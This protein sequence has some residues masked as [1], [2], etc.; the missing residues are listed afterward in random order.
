VDWERVRGL[1]SRDAARLSEGD[2]VQQER[3]DALEACLRLA[4][5]ARQA[6]EVAEGLRLRMGGYCLVNR[7]FA[8]AIRYDYAALV[9]RPDAAIAHNNVG[10]ALGCDNRHDEAIEHLREAVRLDP[11]AATARN[12][13]ALALAATGRYDAAIQQLKTALKYE[14]DSADLHSLLGA[15]LEAK[16]AYGEALVEYRRAVACDGRDLVAQQRLRNFFIRQGRLDEALSAWQAALALKPDNHDAWYGYAELCLYLGRED[17]YRDARRD[18]LTRFAGTKSPQ[19]AER[20]SRACLLLPVAG[21]ELRQAVTLA[22]RAVKADR[23]KHA[24][25]YPH[26]LFARGLADYRQGRF[27]QA[28]AAMRG[29][30]SRALGPAPRLVLGMAL[31]RSGQTAEA[32][33]ALTAAVVR[34]DWSAANVRDQDGWIY[35]TLRREA[36]RLI[37]PD[38]PAFLDG[39]YQPKENDERFALIGICRS[40]GRYR[41]VARLYADAFVAAPPLADDLIARHRYLAAWAAAQAGCGR[42]TDAVGVKEA[43]RARWRTQAREWLRA[44]LAAWLRLLAFDPESHSGV[45]RNVLTHMRDNPGL[46]CVR[47][48]GE[49]TKLAPDERKQYVALWAEVAAAL[50]RTGK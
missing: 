12:N 39:K 1:V 42:G 37:L 40:L 9:L 16:K 26:F 50:A 2:K 43:E 49:L 33:R 28:I 47:D 36:E 19:V 15:T 6:R 23:L 24:G 29:E 11:T 7:R 41:A 30:A 18:L 46:A 13:L 14:P 4:E 32:R 3:A 44:E 5:Q 34:H 17:R 48:P 31:H 35:H 20:V 10:L 38:L 8:D 21:D 22:A 45:V 27:A 25:T